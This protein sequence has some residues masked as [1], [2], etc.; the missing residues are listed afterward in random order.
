[1]AWYFTLNKAMILGA[2]N[3]YAVYMLDRLL[4][5]RLRVRIDKVHKT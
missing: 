5:K 4:A 3:L 1:M 2:V